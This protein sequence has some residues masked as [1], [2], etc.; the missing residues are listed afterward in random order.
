MTFQQAD[1]LRK[2]ALVTGGS[3]GIGRA[4]AIELASRGYDLAIFYRRNEAAFEITKALIEAQGG[5]AIGIQVDVRD[6]ESVRNGYRQLFIFSGRRLDSLVV[7]SGITADGYA[8]MMSA[9]KFLDVIST[10]LIGAFLLSREAIKAMRRTGGSIVLVSSTS[11]ISGQIGQVNYSASKGGMNA[12]TQSLAKECAPNGIRVNAVAPSFTDT[13]MY[14]S[15]NAQAR[16]K[17]EAFIPL[18]RIAQPEEVAKAIAFLATDDAS[19][20]TGVVLPIDG[21]LTA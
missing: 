3:R 6:E 10:N 12:M 16:S 13:D 11:G 14:R 21:G 17:L 18:G 1:P 8:P 5:R 2:M 7:S 15:M 9:G 4:A 20:I 19:Y